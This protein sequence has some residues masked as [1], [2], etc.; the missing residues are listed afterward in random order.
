[1]SR[2]QPKQLARGSRRWWARNMR[3]WALSIR[4]DNPRGFRKP[5]RGAAREGRYDRPWW[6]VTVQP[7]ELTLAQWDHLNAVLRGEK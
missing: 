6:A 4:E 3:D 1:M 2:R 5:M 7:Y